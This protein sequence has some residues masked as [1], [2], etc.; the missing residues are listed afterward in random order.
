MRVVDHVIILLLQSKYQA[1]MNKI[2]VIE[3]VRKG[4]TVYIIDDWDERAIKYSPEL[5]KNVE[6]KRKGCSVV[7]RPMSDKPVFEST[8]D[9][10]EVTK[11]AFE[12]Y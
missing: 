11:E 4:E 2:E 5:G 12:R 8:L 9:G 6:S 3:R 7:M 1:A 10:E